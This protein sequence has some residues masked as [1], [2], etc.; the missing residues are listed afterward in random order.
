M[1]GNIGLI[2]AG[3]VLVTFSNIPFGIEGEIL[4][5]Y[6]LKQS[7]LVLRPIMTTIIISGCIAMMLY[8]YINK[9]LVKLINLGNYYLIP[10][11]TPD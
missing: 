7:S 6:T 11:M 9:Y 5:K 4:D 1:V 8:R 10:R 3:T 2:M